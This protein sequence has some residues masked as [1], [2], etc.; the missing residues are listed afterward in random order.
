MERRR[1]FS[2]GWRHARSRP[3]QIATVKPVSKSFSE[4]DLMK[5]MEGRNSISP[6]VIDRLK[7]Q[8][9]TALKKDNLISELEKC[10]GELEEE[11]D[12]TNKLAEVY[13]KVETE[14]NELLDELEVA[15]QDLQEYMRK[16]KEMEEQ[17]TAIESDRDE[18]IRENE[19]LKAVL[20]NR[21][22]IR[23]NKLNEEN[24]ILSERTKELEMKNTQLV[25][26]INDLYEE[27]QTLINSL[28]NLRSSEVDDVIRRSRSSSLASKDSSSDADRLKLLNEGIDEQMKEFEVFFE[29]ETTGSHETCRKTI[30][31]L[32]AER[33]ELKEAFK[34]VKRERDTTEK[35]LDR[36][37]EE[38]E[39]WENIYAD[40]VREVDQ[41][42]EER[43]EKNLN[44]SELKL[45]KRTIQR[46]LDNIRETQCTASSKVAS[47]LE[48]NDDLRASLK[49]MSYQI[50]QEREEDNQVENYKKEIDEL[51]LLNTQNQSTIFE[52]QAK[53]QELSRLGS[54][55]IKEE[56][57]TINGSSE[58]QDE[59][60][61]LT[62]KLLE[63]DIL[64]KEHE[65][66][67]EKLR[68]NNEHLEAD[69]NELRVVNQ[70]LQGDIDSL[71][72]AYEDLRV[73]SEQLQAESTEIS[74]KLQQVS[75]ERD[76]ANREKEELLQELRTSNNELSERLQKM[77]LEK[78]DFS[79][80][81]ETALKEMS[82]QLVQVRVKHD[83]VRGQL[84]ANCEELTEQVQRLTKEKE[85]AD[86]KFETLSEELKAKDGNIRQVSEECQ[87]HVVEIKRLEN[88]L[89]ASQKEIKEIRDAMLTLRKEK[90]EAAIASDRLKI[91]LQQE[92][93]RYNKVDLENAALKCQ[94]AKLTNNAELNDKQS[95]NRINTL[96]IEIAKVTTAKETLEKILKRKELETKSTKLENVELSKQ[97]DDAKKELNVRD[98]RVAEE[99]IN[100]L[101]E[102]NLNLT[103]KGQ[104]LG[105]LL[106]KN[107]E[108]LKSIKKTID[109]MTQKNQS[110]EVELSN[111]R[112]N[113]NTIKIE[114]D[115]LTKKIRLLER[116]DRSDQ[117]ALE[118]VSLKN[119][120][121]ELQATNNALTQRVPTLN[122]ENSPQL[123]K[124]IN[125]ERE[126]YTM[127]LLKYDEA[128]QKIENLSKE[129]NK[130]K[131]E[132]T[133][134]EAT[135]QEFN[136]KVQDKQKME[137]D[138]QYILQ[139]RKE[140]AETVFSNKWNEI[141]HERDTIKAKYELQRVACDKMTKERDHY[142]MTINTL[143]EENGKLHDQI[144]KQRLISSSTQ[145][146]MIQRLRDE[147]ESLE[148]QIE[149]LQLS[150]TKCLNENKE[151]VYRAE[152]HDDNTLT[153][154]R[155]LK[156]RK[157][158]LQFRVNTL[159]HEKEQLLR[160]LEI[161]VEG[162]INQNGFSKISELEMS[163]SNLREQLMH[164]HAKIAELELDNTDYGKKLQE[165]E[166]LLYDLQKAL[167]QA[168]DLAMQTSL[169]SKKSCRQMEVK[170]D[171]L[172]KENTELKRRIYFAGKGNGEI[173]PISLFPKSTPSAF[174]DTTNGLKNRK[175]SLPV[176]SASTVKRGGIRKSSARDSRSFEYPMLELMPE[177]KTDGYN[178]SSSQVEQDLS[179]QLRELLDLSNDLTKNNDEGG[180]IL[181]DKLT[182]PPPVPPPPRNYETIDRKKPLSPRSGSEG[183]KK[184]EEWV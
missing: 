177:M 105:R 52:L 164:A 15:F 138:I 159:T 4:D 125:E 145:D 65:K 117:L 139:S 13:D 157:N 51:I 129:L 75:G 148:K 27:R 76:T 30:S 68:S 62:E 23:D 128:V 182:T 66:G 152:K 127:L 57:V 101:K 165:S 10:L 147:N 85:I 113:F 107:N 173:S 183:T 59:V 121:K 98:E 72:L 5:Y 17:N 155:S 114:N 160:Q 11:H 70:E 1:S 29:E 43:D 184:D 83:Q 180:K 115:R 92:D 181:S 118:I 56:E 32:N 100:G 54:T 137:R 2:T 36:L 63:K 153:T 94:I 106:A 12:T 167:A 168:N 61:D 88:S 33:L 162:P 122:T 174:N 81:Q 58:D 18:L 71:R 38:K 151:L 116:S 131:E 93:T 149:T 80:K 6:R 44:I 95:K 158:E 28:L 142:I 9:L 99:L 3:P 25:D 178:S 53:V 60:R 179:Q 154:I 96:E 120:N 104:Q 40:K 146:L 136:L 42:I 77:T 119:T 170:N 64:L 73:K 103:Q 166:S 47:L 176:S 133:S 26:E 39:K 48:E 163:E 45:E 132:K 150:L 16:Q 172:V 7:V 143:R 50:D 22:E 171:H 134:L 108:D 20:S 31:E 84:E 123:T 87:S 46:Q 97:L 112:N 82:G 144:R 37:R 8:D 169:E 74:E 175:V 124:S 86:T 130:S 69:I 49:I 78:D 102:E 89:E 14:R 79:L 135:I 91:K 55:S 41:L 110:L 140:E 90:D 111:S 126:K 141:E 156:A 161:K 67:S 19:Y 21:T 35:E 34:R 24:R 109:S